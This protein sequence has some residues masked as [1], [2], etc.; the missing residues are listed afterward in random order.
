[1]IRPCARL[2]SKPPPT[3]S[4]AN[5]CRIRFD[6]GAPYR[7]LALVEQA[8]IQIALDEIVAKTDATVKSFRLASLCSAVFRAEAVSVVVV[9]GSIEFYTKGA[10]TS[11]GLDLCLVSPGS[12]P[13]RMRQSIMGKL[14]AEGGPCSWQVSGIFVDLLGQVEGLAKTSRRKIEGPYGPVE[15]FQAEDLLVERVLVANYP[16]KKRRGKRVCQKTFCR[17][18]KGAIV[19]GLERS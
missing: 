2:F 19:D 6:G 15:M 4:P 9:E 16:I 13:L 7:T 10:Y 17:R 11:W 18:R 3:S 8:A 1:M 14:Q 5:D 12:L